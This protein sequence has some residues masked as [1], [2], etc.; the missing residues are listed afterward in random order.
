MA[1]T[2]LAV[3]KVLIP[4]LKIKQRIQDMA[5]EIMFDHRGKELTVICVLKGS[6]IFFADLIREID[7]PMACEFMGVSSYGNKTT[8]SGE[9][10]LTLDMTEPL[11]GK[12]VVIVE[13]IVD[14]GL[15]MQ[16]LVNNLKQ[17]KPASLKVCSLLVKPESLKCDIE[18][19]YVGFKLG[20]EF[21]VGYGLDHAGKFRQLPYIGVVENEHH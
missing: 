8:S 1:S 4:E 15:T 5:T 3:P 9:V 19:D 16:Y 12:H 10:K 7:L 6:F 21:V 13:D 14:T 11:N 18:I 20:N 2:S 17:R